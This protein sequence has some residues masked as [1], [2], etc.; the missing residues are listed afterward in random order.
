MNCNL[1]DS[2]RYDKLPYHYDLNEIFF[3][4]IANNLNY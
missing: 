2:N 3:R 4:A 1:R